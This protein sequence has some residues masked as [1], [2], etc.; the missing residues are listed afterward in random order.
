MQHYAT[1]GLGPG[2]EKSEG[3]FRAIAFSNSNISSSYKRNIDQILCSI[4]I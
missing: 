1:V 2:T 3:L 4:N